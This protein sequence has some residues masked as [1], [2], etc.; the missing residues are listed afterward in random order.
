MCALTSH[1]YTDSNPPC[2]IVSTL[3]I[4]EKYANAY[5]VVWKVNI[6][7]AFGSVV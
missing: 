7:N 1:A 3:A 2:D 6:I 4:K 5:P